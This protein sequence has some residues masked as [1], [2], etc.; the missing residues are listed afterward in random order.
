MVKIIKTNEYQEQLRDIPKDRLTDHHK[1]ILS[2][3]V[4]PKC[5][6]ISGDDWSQCKGAC[7]MHGSPAFDAKTEDAYCA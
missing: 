4:C 1:F 3:P 2:L 5:G 7:P 6:K